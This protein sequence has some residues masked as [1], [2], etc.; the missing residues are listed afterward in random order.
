MEYPR[1]NQ[2][3][4]ASMI[5]CKLPSDMFTLPKA[6]IESIK[7]AV[8]EEVH[9]F[10]LLNSHRMISYTHWGKFVAYCIIFITDYYIKP[11][12]EEQHKDLNQ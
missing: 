7:D 3:R 6:T 10:K 8:V 12:L 5:F 4:V 2:K 11:A 9:T 1:Q